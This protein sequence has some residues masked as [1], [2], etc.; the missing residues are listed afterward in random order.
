MPGDAADRLLAASRRSSGTSTAVT[1]PPAP[2][3]RDGRSTTGSTATITASAAPAGGRS[4]RRSWARTPAPAAASTTQGASSF[5]ASRRTPPPGATTTSALQTPNGSTA[6]IHASSSPAT[7]GTSTASCSAPVRR[8]CC[9]GDGDE[10]DH[11]GDHR[12]EQDVAGSRVRRRVPEATTTDQRP[13]HPQ[14]G[15]RPRGEGR[16][17][18]RRRPHPGGDGRQGPDRGDPDRADRRQP[19]GRPARP[20]EE[21]DSADGQGADDHGVRAPQPAREESQ[22]RCPPRGAVRAHPQARHDEVRHR[23]VP[24]EHRPLTHDEPLHDEGVPDGGQRCNRR[25]RSAQVR[26]Q[27]ARQS[28]G[29]DT[30]HDEGPPEDERLGGARADHPSEDDP[31][32][33]ARHR[34]RSGRARAQRE[35]GQ[36]RVR[37]PGEVVGEDHAA[38]ER[39]PED[40]GGDDRG[41]G[42]RDEHLAWRAPQPRHARRATHDARAAP[43]AYATASTTR[44]P[45]SAAACTGLPRR[46]GTL[47]PRAMIVALPC[48]AI[49]PGCARL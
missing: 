12:E 30:G 25:G 24:K 37:R 48:A 43:A 33:V 2:H 31:R 41:H 42:S 39:R 3:A 29:A 34:A 17:T 8:S 40:H 32:G 1:R 9:G 27:D 16:D 4:R 14:R 10:G 36:P 5:W 7:A 28:C 38:T 22:R 44:R 19:E 21:K 20:G 47:P 15:V 13:D 6:L 11:H 49:A 26:H 18:G 45:I 35:R 23:G 46:V